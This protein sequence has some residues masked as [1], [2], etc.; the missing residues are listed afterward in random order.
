VYKRQA[1]EKLANDEAQLHQKM[2]AHN[3]D[4]Y[5]GLAAMADQQAAYNDK[6]EGLELEWLEASELLA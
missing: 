4:D 5:D 1:L 2:A 6:R 3:P